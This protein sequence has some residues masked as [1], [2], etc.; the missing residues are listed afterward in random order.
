MRYYSV[1]DTTGTSVAADTIWRASNAELF[2]RV[3]GQPTVRVLPPSFG[4]ASFPENRC[5]LTE[6]YGSRVGIMQRPLFDLLGA[7]VLQDLS[8][9]EVTS[10]S[11]TGSGDWTAFLSCEVR[12]LRGGLKYQHRECGACGSHV[13]QASRPHYILMRNSQFR[14]VYQSGSGGMI[15]REDIYERVKPYA[16]KFHLRFEEL[17]IESEPRDGLG[18]F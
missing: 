12:H 14:S 11:G 16:R 18:W 5:F 15:L 9:A 17:M 8:T 2:C 10:A 13:Y 1:V 3:C 6:D 4:L 7:S